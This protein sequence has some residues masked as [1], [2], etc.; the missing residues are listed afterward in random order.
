LAA[1]TRLQHH[2]EII[3]VSIAEGGTIARVESRETTEATIKEHQIA[4][5]ER[6]TDMFEL[7]DNVMLWTKSIS[8]VEK[9]TE[10]LSN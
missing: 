1:A 10:T 6:S 8:V 2:R 3:S 4:L 7:R 5:V 9:Q